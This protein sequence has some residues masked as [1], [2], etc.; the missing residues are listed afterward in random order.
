VEH[1]LAHPGTQGLI[2]EPLLPPPLLLQ[3]LHRSLCSYYAAPEQG[4]GAEELCTV[5]LDWVHARRPL[6]LAQIPPDLPAVMQSLQLPVA[7][8]PCLLVVVQ[9]M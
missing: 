8:L 9:L 6:D 4:A 2:Q 1:R 5:A 7:D 3:L